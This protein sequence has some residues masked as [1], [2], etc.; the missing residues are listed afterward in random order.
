MR[1]TRRGRGAG[2]ARA[3]QAQVPA[4]QAEQLARVVQEG[5]AVGLP[6]PLLRELGGLLLS[7]PRGIASELL[8]R[9][10]QFLRLLWDLNVRLQI[11]IRGQVVK[12]GVSLLVWVKT[13]GDSS[14][15]PALFP[16]PLHVLEVPLLPR[17]F[18]LPDFYPLRPLCLNTAWKTKRPAK[19]KNVRTH[20]A[21]EEEE[22]EEV[23]KP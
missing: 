5:Q 19:G 14:L 20:R 23:E 9:P 1:A 21:Q 15:P 11:R 13:H 22:E 7:L 10:H 16:H 17:L 12:G 2:G 4:A 6:V 3:R 18:L 8:P